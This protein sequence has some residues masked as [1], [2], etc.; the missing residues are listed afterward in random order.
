MNLIAAVD[1][2]WAIGK[3]GQLLV[4]I[5]HDQ[6][7]FRDMTLGKVIVMGRKT[8]ESLPGGQPL[9]GRV[10]VVLSENRDFRVKGAV[11]CHSM[12]ECM[13]LLSDY[14]PED[15]YII[16]GESIYRQFLPVCGQAEITW[17]D[18]AYSAD[19]HFPDLDRLP[20]WEMTSESEEQ[21]YFDLCYTY[22][23]YKRK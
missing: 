18:F 17:I 21:T 20:D 19:A 22:R 9:Y 7:R 3:G 6:K 16:G 15:I 12:E 10:N 23:I 5:P 1:R 13:K 14:P 11:V 4:S 8:L 2:H